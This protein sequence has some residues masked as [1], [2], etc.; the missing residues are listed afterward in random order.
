M[1]DHLGQGKVRLHE[2]AR[3][4]LGVHLISPCREKF[5]SLGT[6][7]WER[8]KSGQFH[9]AFTVIAANSAYGYPATKE[10]D[11]QPGLFPSSGLTTTGL[12]GLPTHLK[13]PSRVDTFAEVD[14]LAIAGSGAL[15]SP[16][17]RTIVVAGKW[18]C[19][20]ARRAQRAWCS[21]RFSTYECERLAFC[22]S[23]LYE[24]T[25][26]AGAPPVTSAMLTRSHGFPYRRH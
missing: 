20:C 11:P 4:H 21:A 25:S 7:Q 14:G 8:P 16:S 24:G 18:I 22:G 17:Y 12:P 23:A 1:R 13:P 3:N 5:H 2:F 10:P 6:A 26:A 9:G 15:R 19:G